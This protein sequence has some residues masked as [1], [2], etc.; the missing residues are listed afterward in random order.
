[1]TKR[2]KGVGGETPLDH[3][4]EYSGKMV[5]WGKKALL[6]IAGLTRQHLAK[7]L[8]ESSHCVADW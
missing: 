8:Q 1:M 3:P 2:H 6:S 7:I 4:G 5:L